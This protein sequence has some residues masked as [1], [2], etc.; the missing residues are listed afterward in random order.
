LNFTASG[1]SAQGV[2]NLNL[3]P[4][5][6]G[7]S[8]VELDE[9]YVRAFFGPVT[10]EGGVRKL[11][12]GKAD[13]FGPLD[14]VNPLDYRDLTKLS[15]PQSIKISRPMIRTVW[16][17]GAFS[18][19]EA[20]FVPWFEGHKFDTS[21][22]WMPGQVKTL[23]TFGIDA[24]DYLDTRI[25]TLEYFQ[26]GTRFTTSIGSSDIGFQYYY[27]RLPRPAVNFYLAAY[28]PVPEINY[29]AYHQIGMDF[30][31]VIAGFNLRAEAG[32]NITEDTDGTDGAIENPSL[33]WS[34]GFDRNLVWGIKINL[35][36]AGRIRLF[37]DKLGGYMV[38]QG[39][40]LPPI[41][42]DCEAGSGLSSTRITG[43]V[44]RKFFNDEFELK[45]SCLW[46]IEDKDFLIM[47][48]L[49]WRRN[50][51]G[52]ELYVG[53]FGGDREGELGQYH[54]NGFIRM[55]LSYTF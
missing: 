52:A 43:I 38:V 36:G 48:G 25:R 9:A 5:F 16:S 40:P 30:A 29:N 20:V 54:D 45:A 42:T 46:G 19:L 2:I 39:V 21:G 27:G 51:A 50:G 6:D 37:Q 55:I 13:S 15:D 12:W 44:S 35:Q 28:Y 22:R 18:K 26:A 10:V 11:T 17:L 31:R 23:Q 1:G 34:L 32:A 14:V 24:V 4:D 49:I 8:P 53:F 7:S 41:P 47:P 33:V 3:V